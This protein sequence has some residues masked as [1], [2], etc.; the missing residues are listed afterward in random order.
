MEVLSVSR[1]L[2]II[3]ELVKTALLWLWKIEVLNFVT[4]FVD[5]LTAWS[6]ILSGY[7]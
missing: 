1:V 6:L 3:W 5:R 7:S 4:L 2:C